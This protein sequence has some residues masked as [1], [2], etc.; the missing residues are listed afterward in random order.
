MAPSEKHCGC[1]PSLINR[2][3]NRQGG[4]LRKGLGFLVEFIQTNVE[5]KKELE[6]FIFF[7]FFSNNFHLIY[8]ID[9]LKI[10]NVF[11]LR[12]FHMII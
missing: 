9:M 7:V 2:S 11:T 5:L 6:E 1:T 8:S 12:N 3:M 10:L 4:L